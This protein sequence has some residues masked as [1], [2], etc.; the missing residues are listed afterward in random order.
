MKILITAGPTREY[1]D[2]VRFISNPATGTLGFMIAKKAKKK[3]H[4][5]IVIAG[6]CEIPPL[7]GIKVFSVESALEMQD[8]VERYFPLVDVLIMTAAVSDWRPA[9]MYKQKIKIK[10]N[11]KLN[12]IANPDILK[13]VSRRKN[14]NQIIVGF[15]L[16]SENIL[17]NARKKLKKKRLDLIVANSISNF[18]NTSKKTDIFFLFSDGTTKKVFC[19]K[20][21]LA[22]LLLGEIEKLV[23]RKQH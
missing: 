4:D 2:P 22:S 13:T 10:R 21:R 8:R 15:A 11:W 6:P 9:R 17:E 14:R 23:S 3:G 19:T 20:A 16:E 18:G 1:I 5:V 7:K 12:L